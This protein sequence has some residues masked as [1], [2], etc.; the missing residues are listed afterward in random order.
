MQVNC[1]A[2]E[3]QHQDNITGNM[4]ASLNLNTKFVSTPVFHSTQYITSVLNTVAKIQTDMFQT[5]RTA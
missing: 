2:Q 3:S 4:G 1:R 5:S